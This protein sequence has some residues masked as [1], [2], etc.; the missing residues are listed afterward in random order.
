MSDLQS[1]RF[2]QSLNPIAD[3]ELLTFQF[4]ILF[5]TPFDFRKAKIATKRLRNAIVNEIIS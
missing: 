1:K 4:L 2:V 5:S 3:A